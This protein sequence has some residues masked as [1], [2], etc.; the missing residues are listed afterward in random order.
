MDLLSWSASPLV[1]GPEGLSERGLAMRTPAQ[2][3]LPLQ[4]VSSPKEGFGRERLK[5]WAG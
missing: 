5:A 3:N 2:Q 1:C 4:P